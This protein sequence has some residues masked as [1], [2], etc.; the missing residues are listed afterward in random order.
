MC[1]AI[2][3]ADRAFASVITGANPTSPETS[4]PVTSTTATRYSLDKFYGVVIDTEVSQK[5][6]AGTTSSSL[7]ENPPCDD[8]YNQGRTSKS[9]N[10]NRRASP[11]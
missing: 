10:W 9:P 6:T 7:Q 8:R 1:I 2:N 5:S 3:L 4:E 11:I